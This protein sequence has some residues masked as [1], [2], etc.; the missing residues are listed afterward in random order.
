M[1]HFKFRWLRLL[2]VCIFY[3]ELIL[4]FSFA[5]AEI[6]TPVS[7]DNPVNENEEAISIN[8]HNIDINDFFRALARKRKVNII[9]SKDVSGNISVN[10]H[11]I[12]LTRALEAVSL[13]NGYQCLKKNDIYFIVKNKGD[14]KENVG[15]G[16]IVRS[17]R[18]NFA[19]I[20]EVRKVVEDIVGEDHVTIHEDAKTLIVEDSIENIQKV[21]II[22]REVDYPPQQVLIEAKILEITLGDSL[23]FGVDWEKTFI[24]GDFVGTIDTQSLSLP[25]STEGAK[26]FFLDVI[27]NNEKMKAN[28]DALESRA[29]INVLATPKLLAVD[30]KPAEIIIGGRLG[31]YIVTTTETSTLQNVE[32]LDIGTQLKLTPH[33]SKDGKILLE[34]HPEISDGTVDAI[35]LPSTRTT[36]V[37]TSLLAEHGDTI[38]IG[39]LIRAAKEKTK[40]RVP[41]LGSIPLVG[42]FFSRTEDKEA[43]SEIIILITPYII[44]PEEEMIYAEKNDIIK[45]SEEDHQQK[46]STVEKLFSREK[47]F[48]KIQGVDGNG[49]IQ[50]KK[51]SEFSSQPHKNE[52]NPEVETTTLMVPPKIV[53]EN[54]PVIQQEQNGTKEL[55]NPKPKLSY[56]LLVGTFYNQRN[57]EALTQDLKQKKYPAYLL[58][59]KDKKG[60][61]ITAVKVGPMNTYGI[62]KES[63]RSLNSEEGISSII[64]TEEGLDPVG[65]G[66]RH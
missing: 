7:T 45:R 15:I 58:A 52:M 14:G 41:F 4:S 55:L 48:E 34:I 63:A 37:S 17:F 44:S 30:G 9:T 32:F 60:I 42:T 43:K 53:E 62:A 38:F 23:S 28:L 19:E 25:K 65:P 36:E 66:S 22:L 2:M 46:R 12:P 29:D 51:R 11:N 54:P 20:S 35:G 1:K 10:L 64:I 49:K 18:V 57:A 40:S 47:L 3:L 16:S 8:V 39:G 31:Y 56:S 5:Q 59:V 26:G 33:I 13:A 50:I 21:E 6:H 27:K 61:P 24:S